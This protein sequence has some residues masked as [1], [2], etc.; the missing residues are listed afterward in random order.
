MCSFLLL[1]LII[2]VVFTLLQ[3]YSQANFKYL[4]EAGKA[5]SGYSSQ[6]LV[7]AQIREDQSDLEIIDSGSEG[8]LETSFQGLCLYQQNI[9]GDPSQDGF[10]GGIPLGVP[11]WT[12]EQKDSES[13]CIVLGALDERFQTR[14]HSEEEHICW[15]LAMDKFVGKVG[16]VAGRTSLFRCS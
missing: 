8:F 3:D 2:V 6:K 13:L 16:R 14:C 5:P 15:G 9:V 11:M 10:R 12:P 7:S 1:F 4:A